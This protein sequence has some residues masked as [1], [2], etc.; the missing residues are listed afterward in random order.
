MCKEKLGEVKGYMW[1]RFSS[2]IL[3]PETYQGLRII[4]PP[5]CPLVGVIADFAQQC[6]P[7]D[8]Y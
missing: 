8:R 2:K 6:G 7:H 3:Q 1:T 4:P 5:C